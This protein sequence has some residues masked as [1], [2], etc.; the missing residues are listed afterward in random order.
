MVRGPSVDGIAVYKSEVKDGTVFAHVPS[1]IATGGKHQ[2]V[3]KAG[4]P[5]TGG[6]SSEV[7]IA[8]R[9]RPQGSYSSSRRSEVESEG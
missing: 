6:T 3:L 2:R 4:V 1:E 5:A 8:R 9:G 7:G